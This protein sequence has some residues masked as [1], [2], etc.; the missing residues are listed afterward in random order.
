MFLISRPIK[1]IWLLWP[2]NFT[3]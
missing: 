3:W 2:W 1:S